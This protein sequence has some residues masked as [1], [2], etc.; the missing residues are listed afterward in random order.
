MTMQITHLAVHQTRF[1]ARRGWSVTEHIRLLDTP[2]STMSKRLSADN[3]P[4]V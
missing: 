1:Y 3:G 2:A 4:D